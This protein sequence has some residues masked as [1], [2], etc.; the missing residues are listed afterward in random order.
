MCVTDDGGDGPTSKRLCVDET[1][2]TSAESLRLQL[3][4]AQREA[5]RFKRQLLCKQREADIYKEQLTKIAAKP[6][7][8]E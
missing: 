7:A 6:A 4:Q 5:A 2:D 3:E 1:S 8:V